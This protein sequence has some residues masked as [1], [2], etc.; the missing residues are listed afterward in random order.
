MADMQK[1]VK[2]RIAIAPILGLGE[3]GDVVEITEEQL[4]RIGTKRLVEVVVADMAPDL[5]ALVEK[6][7]NLKELVLSLADREQALAEREKA[8]S[9]RE[10][11]LVEKSTKK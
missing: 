1:T 4:E 10:K 9:E 3:V 7:R 6:E 5:Q 2:R 8:L 11:A